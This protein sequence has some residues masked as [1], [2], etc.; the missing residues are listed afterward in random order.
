MKLNDKQSARFKLTDQGYLVAE[1]TKLARTGPMEYL[2][3]ELGKTDNNVYD[4]YIDPED[5]F[6]DAAMASYEG[7]PVTINHP[8]EMEVNAQNWS[9]LSV[10]HIKNIRPSDD[11]KFLLGDVIVNSSKAIDTIQDGLIEV[12]L[13]YD[14]DIQE[15]DGKLKKVNIRGNH[16]A[17]VDEGRCGSDCKLNIND[18]K[19]KKMTDK[20]TILQKLFGVKAK[21][22]TSRK[23]FGDAKSK[24]ASAKKRLNDSKVDFDKKLKD[25]EEVVVSA[26]ATVEEK[27][28][29][30]QE[31]QAE[32]ASLM[33]EATAVVDEAQAATEQAEELAAQIEED[34]P[35]AT[36][37]DEDV[38]SVAAEADQ[39]IAD[40]EAE[41]AELKAKVADLEEQLAALK[42]AED[43]SAAMN[44]AKTVFTKA[45]FKDS[46][47]SKEIKATA[48]ASTGAYTFGDAMKLAD[49][50]LNSA[51]AAAKTV[52]GRKVNHGKSFVANDAKA[53]NNTPKSL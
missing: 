19:P 20:K 27:A 25:A 9:E 12:S 18:G 34:A 35:T 36:V 8:E 31:L 33:E 46:M 1:G 13:G 15:I 28:A 6:N 4:V 52:A 44:D 48:V 40:L 30:V 53:A 38:A 14:A 26:D 17:A 49:C 47:S 11:K 50:A 51:Y 21:A 16:L 10:G 5:L 45:T 23:K 29:A 22:P 42:E 2:G 7:M 32:A 3:R 39:K 43:K 41:N 24:I 37:T